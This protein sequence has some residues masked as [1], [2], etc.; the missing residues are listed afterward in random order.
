MVEKCKSH[1]LLTAESS[2]HPQNLFLKTITYKT[3]GT[4]ENN[5]LHTLKDLLQIAVIVT[6]FKI[7]CDTVTCKTAA[8][9]IAQITLPKLS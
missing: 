2:L 4:P 1:V 3:N 8:C 6:P 9:R 7:K 5:E